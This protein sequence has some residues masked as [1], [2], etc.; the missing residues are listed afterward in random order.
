LLYKES[1]YFLEEPVRV[2]NKKDFDEVHTGNISFDA[3][4]LFK[5]I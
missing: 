4:N 3:P 2:K 5:I 1:I